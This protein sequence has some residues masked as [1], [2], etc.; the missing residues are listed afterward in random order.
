MFGDMMNMMGKLKETQQKVEETKKRLDSVLIDEKSSDNLIEVTLTANR[1]ITNISIDD[2]TNPSF[3]IKSLGNLTLLSQNLNSF[4]LSTFNHSSYSCDKFTSK[5]NYVLKFKPSI[6]FLQDLRLN[7]NYNIVNNQFSCHL[8][9]NYECILNS[10]GASRGTAICLNKSIDYKILSTH[11][12]TC[13]NI[14]IVEVIINNFKILLC[15][16]YAPP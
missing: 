4:N 6:I 8:H 5:L 9:G 16:I 15:C 2:R 7:S 3:E 1:K 12:S 14:L 13:D 11:L 10:S